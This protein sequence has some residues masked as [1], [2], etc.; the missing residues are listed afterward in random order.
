[1]KDHSGFT[2]IEVMAAMVLFAGGV[3]MML[4]LAQNLARQVD[5][6]A[7][8]TEVASIARAQADSLEALG[9]DGLT[10]GTLSPSTIT[11]RPSTDWTIR[12]TV[13]QYSPLVRQ[14]TVSVEPSGHGGPTRSVSL[15][16]ATE[17]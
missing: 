5:R 15:W 11:L 14:V 9:Y 7:L 3:L 17:W 6:S 4:S 13:T 16:V 10:V 1:M 8:I 12:R 2:L